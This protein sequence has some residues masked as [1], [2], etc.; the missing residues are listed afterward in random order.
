MNIDL[1]SVYETQGAEA[2]NTL[3]RFMIIRL[4]H[5]LRVINACWIEQ[6]MSADLVDIAT[7]RSYIARNSAGVSVVKYER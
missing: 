1:A 5:D 7:L 6:G 4:L 3:R 2:L